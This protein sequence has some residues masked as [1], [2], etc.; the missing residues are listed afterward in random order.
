MKKI[1]CILATAFLLSATL[2]MVQSGMVSAEGDKGST[3]ENW[4]KKKLEKMTTTLGLSEDQAAQIETLMNEKME[5]KKAI[6]DNKGEEMSALREKYSADVKALLDDEQ[7]AKYDE[8]KAEYHKGSMKGSGHEHGGSDMK[9][10]G[11]GHEHGG[12]DMGAK[13][14]GNEHG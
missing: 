13:G 10:K 5:A 11:S 14:S 4:M 6:T 1:A 8:M 2:V 7:K 3:S 9:A 12:S